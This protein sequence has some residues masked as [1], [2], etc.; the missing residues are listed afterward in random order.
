MA[1]R[2][3]GSRGL[4][5]VA[6]AE[7]TEP[8]G[9]VGV[10]PDPTRLDP[11]AWYLLA[12]ALLG[13][14]ISMNNGAY[15]PRAVALLTAAAALTAGACWRLQQARGQ[16]F[17]DIRPA[18]SAAAAVALVVAVVYDP[19]LYGTGNVLQLSRWATTGAAAL[20][21]VTCLADRWL[22]RV[23]AVAALALST[24]AGG[25]M[26]RASPTPRIDVWYILT[27]GATKTAQGHNIYTSCWPGNPDPLT[28]CVYPYLPMTTVAQ[29]PFRLL[30]DI[31]Y[32]YIAALLLAAAAL[33]ALLG[34]EA[35]VPVALLFASPKLTFLLEQAWTEPLLLAALCVMVAATVRGHQTTAIL[36]FAFAL[37]CKQHMVLLIPLAAVWPRFGIR[38]TALS[39]LLAGALVL[40]WLVPDPTAFIQDAWDFNLHLPPRA[41]SL[42]FYTTAVLLGITPHFAVVVV[43]TAAV[44]AV[45][46]F[47][48]PRT[49]TGFVAGATATQFVFDL[50]NKQTFFNHWWLVSGLLLLTI[51]TWLAEQRDRREQVSDGPAT[52]VLLR[53]P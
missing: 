26:I 25:L 1:P 23:A 24:V 30:G 15:L 52:R 48:L 45:C 51:T 3:G 27:V 34:W 35:A 8:S 13:L 20:A 33:F 40:A 47:R 19:G 42:S 36:A 29:L 39:V 9:S 11:A 49:A 50:L 43:M 53:S 46:A 32:S 18:A 22:S 2:T 6:D 12:W 17:L 37:A 14:A 5:R 41:D 31:R 21:L 16:T 38:R 44:I 7:Q 28:D 10:D 4:L